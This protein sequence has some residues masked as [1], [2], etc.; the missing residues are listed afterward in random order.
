MTGIHLSSYGKD[1][2]RPVPLL[3]V[4]G[5]VAE[6]EGIERIRLGSLEP[7]IVTEE[8]VRGLSAISKVCPHFHLSLQS[9]CDQTLR[10]MNRHYTTQEY[11]ACCEL[12]R[13]YYEH[14]AITTDVIVGFP[15]ETEEEFETT[16]SFLERISFYEMHVFKY[17]KRQGTKAA[18][19][20][21]QVPE[22][23]KTNRSHRV[24]ALSA[25][26]SGDFRKYYEGKVR[27]ILLEEEQEIGGRRHMTGFTKE[28]VKAAVEL[29]DPAAREALVPGRILPVR[30]SG[31][32]E[33]GW[34]GLLFAEP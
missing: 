18:A 19:M 33:A 25:R 24:L 13:S 15:G 11:A 6:V 22:E 16:L 30:L 34:E 14:P 20:G 32:R 9:G 12:L 27:G 17:S 3:T 4:I 26:L 21:S 2:E 10:R 8:F 28:Y 23:V 1:F 7:R 5:Q 31:R 29:S